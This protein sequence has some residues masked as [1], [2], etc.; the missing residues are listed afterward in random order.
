MKMS[1]IRGIGLATVLTGSLSGCW[2]SSYAPSEETVAELGSIKDV[3]IV[4]LKTGIDS[5]CE[6]HTTNGKDLQPTVTCKK[7]RWNKSLDSIRLEQK[8]KAEFQR[9]KNFVYDSL[10]KVNVANT[11]QSDSA[12]KKLVNK[13]LERALDSLAKG[14]I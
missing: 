11:V 14:K 4:K 1:G 5:Y 3:N 9:G 13:F 10:A 6:T 7:E 12:V 2:L 8:A